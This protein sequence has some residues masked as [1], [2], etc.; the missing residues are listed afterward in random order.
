[1]KFFKRR[2]K[3]QGLSEKA[4][5]NAGP[6]YGGTPQIRYAGEEQDYYNG[7]NQASRSLLSQPSPASARLVGALPDAAL[8]RIF[9]FV[10]PHTQD[11]TYETQ[12]QS[13]IED[14]C[15]LCDLRDL[16][17]C[18]QVCRKWRAAAV[19]V[20]YH[21]IRIDTVHYCERE[22]QLSEKRKRRSFFDRN[23]EPEDPTRARLK[24]L[25]RTLRE[26][27]SRLGPIVEYFKTPYMLRESCQADLARTIAVLPNLRYVD[28]PEGLF[29]D[30]PAYV[31]LRLEVQ[32]RCHNLRKMTYMAGSERS[33]ASL[34]GG[35]IWRSL[36]VV[37]LAGI[38]IDPTVLLGSLCVLGNLR[39]LKVTDSQIVTDEVIA[40]TNNMLPAFPALEELVL[41]N[42]PGVTARGLRAYLSRIDTQRALKVLNLKTTGVMPWSLPEVLGSAPALKHLTIQETVSASLPS[43][44]G[45]V[46][47]P[48]LASLSL[49]TLHYE[50][51]AAQSSSPF[52][53]TITSYYN[54]LSGS[55]LSGGL[56]RLRAVYVRD[57][58]FADALAGLPP[59]APAFA[60]G[61]YAR[62]AS[63]GTLS[64]AG[65]SST[66][67]YNSLGPAMS[68]AG[69]LSP[70]NSPGFVPY[71]NSSLSPNPFQ[72]PPATAQSPAQKPWAPGHQP[73]FSSNNPFASPADP[74]GAA[75]LPQ[76]LEVFTKGDDELD[77]SFVKVEPGLPAPGRRA[78]GARPVSSYGLDSA[79]ASGW[80][81]GAG[82]RKSVF[83]G[84]GAGGFLAVPEPSGGGGGGGGARRASTGGQEEWPRPVSSGGRKKKEKFDL[85]R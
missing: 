45:T 79:A 39:A 41:S 32:A 9:A 64:S 42:V 65:Y 69:F 16:A 36:E 71:H 73:R 61:G 35:N 14:A 84:D 82:A 67:S 48:P 34:A 18:V 26:D 1:M 81:A 23:G 75:G 12:E 27:P 49:E 66:M 40:H 24:L 77:W 50:I 63:S 15:M 10:C 3:R 76:T 4:S 60:E 8:E 38:N 19:R 47:I 28:L 74:G 20:L 30:E 22:G 44:A 72:T 55:L 59:P 51:Q 85:W 7:S 25:C 37:E 62:P 70:Q 56:P 78:N 33:L 83:L 68:P 52:V 53:S 6:Y 54:Y 46:E 21:S 13:S 31:T 2:D 57:A 5:G 17:H 58:H 29:M 80:N 11:E 43:A